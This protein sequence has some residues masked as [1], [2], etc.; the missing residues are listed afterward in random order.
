MKTK[1][2]LAATFGIGIILMAG[3]QIVIDGANIHLP[4]SFIV[5]HTLLYFLVVGQMIAVNG[6]KIEIQSSRELIIMLSVLVSVAAIGIVILL[7][8]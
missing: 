4:K 8:V 3:E 1:R 5:I 6:S 2:I 7:L